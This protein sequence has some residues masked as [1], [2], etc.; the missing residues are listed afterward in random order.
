VNLTTNNV[1]AKIQTGCL[2]DKSAALPLELTCSNILHSLC[3]KYYLLNKVL[4]TVWNA[5]V[6]EN[7]LLYGGAWAYVNLHM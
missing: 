3:L 1:H 2:L 6:T 5:C 7:G 4:L